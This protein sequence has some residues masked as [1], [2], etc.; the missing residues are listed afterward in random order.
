M[1]RFRWTLFGCVAASLTLSACGSV[2]SSSSAPS[3]ATSSRSTSTSAAAPAG[4]AIKVGFIC[5]CSGPQASLLAG[6]EKVAQAWADSV[7]ASGGIN[8]HPVKLFADDDGEDPAK[9]LQDAKALVEQDHV[10]A[11]V[12]EISEIDGAWVP[13]V[14]SQGI[15]IV[16]GASGN[17]AQATSPGVFPSGSTLLAIT[18]GTIAEAKGKTNFGVMYCAETPVC[19]QFVPLATGVGKLFGLKVTATSISA[20]APSYAA[21]CLKFKSAGVDALLV[22]D[23][24]PVVQRVVAACSQQGYAPLEVTTEAATTSTMLNDS[25]LAGTLAAGGNAN[26][27]DSSSPAVKE[28]QAAVQKYYPGLLASAGYTQDDFYAW[29]GGKLFEAAA[30]AANIGPTSTPAEVETGLYSLKNETL[31]GIA[32]PLT[33]TKGKPFFTPC[34]FSAKIENGTLSSVNGNRPV[35]L[36]AVQTAAL[37]KA[38]HLG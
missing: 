11:I 6:S 35:C 28:F 5:S 4:A 22:G 27:F 15:P 7:N 25:Q 12:G 1:V 34:W 17:P 16:G 26:P 31:G 14:V 29:T 24:G 19:A 9:G 37:V 23:N 20:T 3:A 38:L 2:S 33:Y 30:K 36:S 8:G 32:P 10:I 18:V 13:W 21:P